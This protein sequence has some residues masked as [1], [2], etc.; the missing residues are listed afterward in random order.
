[1]LL[2]SLLLLALN[3]NAQNSLA[4]YVDP[5]IGTGG[6]G[7]TFPG[8]TVPFGMVQLSPDSRL[9]GWDG[10]GGYHYTDTVIYGFSHTHLSGTGVS[11]YGDVLLMPFT[12]KT[13]FNNGSDGKAG[14]S[15]AFSKDTETA[16]AGYYSVLLDKHKINVELTATARAGFHNYEFPDQTEMKLIIDLQHRDQLTS[17]EFIQNDEFHITGHRYSNA[18]AQDQRLHF[19]IKFDKAIKNIEYNEDKTIAA[20]SF[21]SED[22]DTSLKIHTGISAVDI[23]GAVQNREA[24]LTHWDFDTVRH[25]ATDAWEKE[26]SKI[27]VTSTDQDKLKVFYTALYHTMIAPNLYTDVDGRYRGTDFEI[28]TATDH[29]Q[30]TIFSLW[31]TYRAAHPLYTIIDEGRT[32]DFIKTF[33]HHYEEG[34]SLPMWELANNY[35]G[36]MIGYHAV[37]V[38]A[39]AYIKGIR[40]YDAERAMHAMIENATADKLGIPDYIEN[41]FLPAEIEA[42][43][44]S[45][46]LEYSYDDWTIAQMANAMGNQDIA[47]K[48]YKRGQNYKNVFDAET[49]FMRARMNNRWFYPFNPSEVNY[50]YTEANAWQYSYSVPHDVNG[51]MKLLGGSDALSSK[52][53]DLFTAQSETSGRD[54]VDITGLIGQYAHGN[55][56]S[57]HI[58]YLYNFV[59]EAHKTQAITRQIMEDL[60]TSSS[61]GYSG[62]EDCGQMSAWLVLSSLGFYPV[63]PGSD[64]YIIGSPW[65]D[66]AEI[67]LENGKTFTINAENNGDD[68]VYIQEISLNSKPYTQSYLTHKMI[69][70]GSTF[71]INMG[72]APSAFGAKEEDRPVTEI[73]SKPITAVPAVISG[74]RAFFE[75]TEVVLHCVTNNADIYYQVNNLPEKLYSGPITLSENTVLKVRS[76]KQGHFSSA[77]VHSTFLKM[78]ENRSITLSTKYGNHYAAGG[79]KALIDYIRGGNDYRT[80][81]WQGYE[82]VDLDAVVDL[83]SKSD[84]TELGIGFLQDENSWIFMPTEVTFYVSKYGK[85]YKEVG[86]VKTKLSPK[87]KGFIVTDYTVKIN[88]KAR[89]IKVVA[90]NRGTCPD[91]HKGAGGKSWIFADE[92]TIK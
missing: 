86:N 84:L 89:F 49:G 51:W 5:F 85:K 56:P 50:N 53:D 26:L 29:T 20:I 47:D 43:C 6:H 35:T 72:S 82:G 31:D 66:K 3:S 36:C 12:G 45:K 44:V 21:K 30:Y 15:S 40:G 81:N 65:F 23:K 14:Y 60:Y 13:H 64:S 73:L 22:N 61:D 18:W 69:K 75:T 33:I 63:T 17:S 77:I 34:G 74:E 68:N 4:D 10:C 9:D 16:K 87:D 83:G 38:I 78:E 27:K 71:N 28:H 24:E 90:K 57:H 52:L 59:G 76:A 54:Q 41:G 92:I 1:M 79:D 2:S 11:D 70:D 91:Y 62:N 7:H 67:N 55:E 19:S 37:P 39:D 42:E 88:S 80:G 25:Q 8:A 48:Y 46:T 32:N 58:A